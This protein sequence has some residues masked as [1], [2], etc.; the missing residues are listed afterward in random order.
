MLPAKA[1]EAWS[2][3]SARPGCALLNS[4]GASACDVPS[5]VLGQT[6]LHQCVSMPHP[7]QPLA[8]ALAKT[9]LRPAAIG[10]FGT[11]ATI[12]VP[13][14]AG[15]GTEPAR[16]R[17][18]TPLH[19]AH[20]QPAGRCLMPSHRSAAL[21]PPLAGCRTPAAPA[22]PPL[23]FP[24]ESASINLIDDSLEPIPATQTSSSHIIEH[25]RQECS[26]WELS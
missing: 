11:P 18:P 6:L 17:R 8:L 22:L 12:Q 7:S 10:W 4:L 5:L 23:P 3:A 24:Q 26:P 13:L 19:A 2:L 20:P 1:A 9:R 25:S 21:R 15:T 14:G 16:W